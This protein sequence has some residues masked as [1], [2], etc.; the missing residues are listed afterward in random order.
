MFSFVFFVSQ[1]SLEY[2]SRGFSVSLLFFFSQC[3]F[4]RR[5]LDR[6]SWVAWGG[7]MFFLRLSFVLVML[8]LCFFHAFYVL[9][10]P[11]RGVIVFT[12]SA[13]PPGGCPPPGQQL[14]LL[15]RRHHNRLTQTSSG[16]AALGF[17]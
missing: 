12:V 10:F 5:F 4:I 16:R 6:F 1:K 2:F 11:L 9:S 15:P 3:S 7:M 13:L 17:L 14:H 8:S